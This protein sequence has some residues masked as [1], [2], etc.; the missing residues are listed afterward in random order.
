M[1]Y[2]YPYLVVAGYFVWFYLK[3]KREPNYRGGAS[4]CVAIMLQELILFNSPN[5]M[6]KSS[7]EYLN[8]LFS[9]FLLFAPT[10]VQFI[11]I[12]KSKSKASGG[13]IRENV[14]T[15]GKL[16][17]GTVGITLLIGFSAIVLT[18]LFSV[19]APK[20]LHSN[21]AANFALAVVLSFTFSAGLYILL[22]W[23]HDKQRKIEEVLLRKR[24]GS[25][26]EQEKIAIEIWYQARFE[27]YQPFSIAMFFVTLFISFVV[28]S[29]WFVKERHLTYL[30][31][32]SGLVGLSVGFIL[33]RQMLNKMKR[34]A[35]EFA[36]PWAVFELLSE[37]GVI[38]GRGFKKASL[39]F[40]N[41]QK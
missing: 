35:T 6:N 12:A 32:G 13:S 5:E 29:H 41:R 23:G 20:V 38:R 16:L 39:L 21:L 4:F 25:L 26:N 22:R 40:L 9:L 37:Q 30:L 31:L 8:S 10:T 27:S 7:Y 1:I 11:Q 28:D 34:K 14:K 36:V 19:L 17:V 2:L 33:S 3:L 24:E 15:Y 18:T